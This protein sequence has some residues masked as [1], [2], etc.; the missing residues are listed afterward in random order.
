LSA[1][2][3][4][5]LWMI[6]NLHDAVMARAAERAAHAGGKMKGKWSLN[7]FTFGRRQPGPA[8]R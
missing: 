1:P 2:D 8:A 4:I 7:Y 6:E 5:T 3:S